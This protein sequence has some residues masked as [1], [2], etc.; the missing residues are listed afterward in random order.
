MSR[1]AARWAREAGIPVS[2]DAEEPTEHRDALFRLTDIL[3]VGRRFGRMLTGQE[4]PR[5]I[6][7]ALAALGPSVVGLTLA[8]DGSMLLHRGEIVEASGFP[9]PVV[10]TTGAGDVFH[11]AF[12][13]GVLQGWEAGAILTF[14]NAVSALKCTHLGGR[15]G[16]PSAT[17]AHAFLRSRGVDLSRHASRKESER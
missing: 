4:A 11:G 5:D 13:Y 10:D 1:T 15:S 17:E 2:M 14:A 16:I 9:V 7:R 12:V 8:E 6:L 3:F